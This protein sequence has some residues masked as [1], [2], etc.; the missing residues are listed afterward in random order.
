MVDSANKT[1]NAAN[2]GSAAAFEFMYSPTRAKLLYWKHADLDSKCERQKQIL[3][4]EM[5]TVVK[6]LDT[7]RT[8]MV[9][10]KDRLDERLDAIFQEK[11]LRQVLA[12]NKDGK[13][14]QKNLYRPNTTQLE[15]SGP[16]E[17][18]SPI[19]SQE[20][21]E[22]NE[23]DEGTDV[24][25]G[26]DVLSI[27][28]KN[29]LPDLNTNTLEQP[30]PK[31]APSRKSAISQRSPTSRQTPARKKS[32]TL[33]DEYEQ[34]MRKN[35]RQSI[36]VVNLD[37]TLITKTVPIKHTEH[38][39]RDS[40]PPSDSKFKPRPH[41]VPDRL[42]QLSKRDEDLES[43]VKGFIERV[44]QFKKEEDPLEAM[45][46]K[47]GGNYNGYNGQDFSKQNTT[48]E[49]K[50]SNKGRPTSRTR[51]SQSLQETSGKKLPLMEL[52]S[53]YSTK[54]PGRRKTMCQVDDIQLREAWEKF[55]L[56]ADLESRQ[57][58][59]ALTAKLKFKAQK[60][61]DKSMVP[62]I[63][64]LRASKLWKAKAE[65]AIKKRQEDRQK[66][67]DFRD[68][69]ANIKQLK[70]MLRAKNNFKKSKDD[71]GMSRNTETKDDAIEQETSSKEPLQEAVKVDNGSH[72]ID[73]ALIQLQKPNAIVMKH[74]KDPQNVAE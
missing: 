16:H 61:R 10:R 33:Q 24:N 5:N 47:Q 32:V 8:I 65:E 2:K 7:S 60:E 48:I 3:D 9:R 22:T 11:V 18:Q 41:T 66:M 58:M 44:N 31:S 28:K 12:L 50:L 29:N 13:T 73:I 25:E 34:D 74:D 64:A 63:G 21:L 39:E 71:T 14:K 45:L 46:R 37:N 49:G 59:A 52:P 54:T 1:G 4:W 57:K 15:T 26:P 72:L 38:G 6:G 53:L 27:V 35:D 68:P 62:S 30:L 55:S 43:R 69:E 19:S 36:E 23:T 56:N 20:P 17:V 67:L 42:T 70:G 51:R 40:Y